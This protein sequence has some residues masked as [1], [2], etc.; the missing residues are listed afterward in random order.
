MKR[1]ILISFAVCGAIPAMAQISTVGAFSGAASEGFESYPTYMNGGR[2]GSMDIM[3]GAA[4][5][6]S[7]PISGQK[8]TVF[9]N[10]N[11]T[12]GLT[13]IGFA[14]VYAGERAVG[15]EDLVTGQNHD[16]EILFTDGAM[17]FG[18][19]FSTSNNTP[20]TV[21]FF[22]VLDNQIGGDQVIDN[23]S[24]DAAWFG[25]TST[26]TIARAEFLSDASY[27]TMD[28]LQVNSVP[29]PATMALLGLG[30][31]ALIRRRRK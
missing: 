18:G 28:E 23:P 27:M 4:T 20:V 11:A 29:E 13:G 5:I 6:N 22:D 9:D 17:Q 15:L 16:W 7:L 1:L 30:A 8:F 21:R 25:W 24:I 2:Y 31:A 10:V 19:Y 12:W 3:G 26:V 14:N